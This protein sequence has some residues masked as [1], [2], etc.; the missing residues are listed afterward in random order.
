MKIMTNPQMAA[1]NGLPRA[2]AD[3]GCRPQNFAKSAAMLPCKRGCTPQDINKEI[4]MDSKDIMA[5]DEIKTEMEKMA[6]SRNRGLGVLAEML[7][8][9]CGL[10]ATIWAGCPPEDVTLRVADCHCYCEVGLGEEN[11]QEMLSAYLTGY[12]LA[13]SMFDDAHPKEECAQSEDECVELRGK[14]A[15]WL[16]EHIKEVLQLVEILDRDHELTSGEARKVLLGDLTQDGS[17]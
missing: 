8:G 15:R 5:E 16:W 17:H 10:A 11:T 2:E 1:A 13:R 14:V 9:A 7:K 4:R 6:P 3:G 12:S